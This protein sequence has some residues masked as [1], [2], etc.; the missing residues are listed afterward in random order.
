MKLFIKL[1][2]LKLIILIF[3]YIINIDNA[4]TKCFR[5]LISELKKNL[6]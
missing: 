1:F 5:F 6:I 3:I 2:M 4:N